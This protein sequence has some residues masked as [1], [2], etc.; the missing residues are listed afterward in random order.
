MVGDH[1]VHLQPPDRVERRT[2][3]PGPAAQRYRASLYVSINNLTNHANLSGFS[4]V[5]T[6]PFFMTAT[7]V[8][9]PRKVDLGFNIAF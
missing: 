5:M 9:N 3:R 2:G 6:S 8:Q 1:A 4:G 7:S